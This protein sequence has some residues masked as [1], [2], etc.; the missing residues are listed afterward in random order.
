M[1]SAM[2]FEACSTVT[3][4]LTVVVVRSLVVEGEEGM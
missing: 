1:V 2:T 3:A 4:E